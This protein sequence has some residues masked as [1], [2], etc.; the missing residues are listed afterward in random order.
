M[1]KHT[2][3]PW[4]YTGESNGFDRAFIL[5][6]VWAEIGPDCFDNLQ[7]AWLDEEAYEGRDD[8]EANARLIAAAPDLLAALNSIATVG[9]H[10]IHDWRA[11]ALRMQETALSAIA[12]AEGK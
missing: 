5:A 12:K 2:P 9:I 1:S 7:V 8:C 4:T 10:E 3:G 6:S 11:V